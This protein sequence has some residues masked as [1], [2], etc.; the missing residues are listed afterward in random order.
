MT[1]AEAVDFL[2]E[3]VGHERANATAEVRRSFNGSYPPLYQAGYM[4]GGL[5]FRALH[6]EVVGSG[7]M[8]ERAFH[9]AIL[10]G[11]PMPVEMVRARLLGLELEPEHEASWRFYDR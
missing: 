5:Q 7:L 8:T 1:P 6:E 2:V 3:Q 4:L 9:D 11:G 10:E